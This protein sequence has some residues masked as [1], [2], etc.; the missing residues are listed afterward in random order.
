MLSCIGDIDKMFHRSTELAIPVG[1]PPPSELPAQFHNR[2]KVFEIIDSEYPD[3]V[4][5]RLSYLLRENT[6]TDEY[7]VAQYDMSQCLSHGY[8]GL[9]ETEVHGPAQ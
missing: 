7:I 3:Y 6:D 1:Y 5:L 8:V 4:Y 9:L 2:V